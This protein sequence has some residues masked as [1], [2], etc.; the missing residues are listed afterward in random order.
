MI[1]TEAIVDIDLQGV[2]DQEIVIDHDH[3]IVVRQDDREVE[4]G[5]IVSLLD[6]TVMMK[7]KRGG[8]LKRNL[9][10]LKRNLN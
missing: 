5:E 10:N 1:D 8:K 4:I 6:Q 3:V 7:Q 2:Q 9:S